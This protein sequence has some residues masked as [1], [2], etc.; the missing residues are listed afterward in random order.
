M[1]NDIID[2]TDVLK[3]ITGVF[4]KQKVAVLATSGEDGPYQS[5]VAYTVLP[6]FK[7]IVFATDRNTTKFNNIKKVPEVSL[8]MDNRTEKLN[9]FKNIIVVTAVGEAGEVEGAFEDGP[10][11]EYMECHP[12]LGE[13][14]LTESSALI[15]IKIKK[16]IVVSKFSEVRDYFP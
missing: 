6:G 5:L 16:Y 12:L 11:K 7:E 10:G 9:D 13:K 1:K 2:D 3:S 15:R 14:F 8:L 4:E